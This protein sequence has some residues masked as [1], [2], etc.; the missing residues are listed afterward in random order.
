MN[1]GFNDIFRM[2]KFKKELLICFM[3]IG[4]FSMTFISQEINSTEIII[5]FGDVSEQIENRSIPRESVETNKQNLQKPIDQNFISDL[6]ANRQ[7]LLQKYLQ[8]NDV[9]NNR[10]LDGFE[11]Q[12]SEK[13]IEQVRAV[14]CLNLTSIN[15]ENDKTKLLNFSTQMGH[16][17]LSEDALY[18]SGWWFSYDLLK[19]GVECK[20]G[21]NF[22]SLIYIKSDAP[23]K[24]EMMDSFNQ[25]QLNN[26][27]LNSYGL[28]GDPDMRLAIIDRGIDVNHSAIKGKDVIWR[29]FTNKNYPNPVD[30]VGHGTEIASIAVGNH[31]NA[32]DSENRTVTSNSMYINWG[33]AGWDPAKTYLFFLGAINV[34]SNGTLVYNF[35]WS[36]PAGSTINIEKIT[37]LNENGAYTK[38][39][40]VSGPDS[41]TTLSQIINSTDLGI[42][43]FGYLFKASIGESTVHS[44]QGDIHTPL[45]VI[46]QSIQNGSDPNYKSHE[47]HGIAPNVKLAMIRVEFESDFI[48]GMTWLKNNAK[49]YNITV[50]SISLTI[51]S[52]SV[53]LLA[54]E[55]VK[56]GLVV[57]CAA[58]N[59]GIGG[60]EAGSVD[61]APGS[62]DLA[63]SVGA[64]GRNNSVSSFSA[65]GG[66]SASNK[67]IKPDI[68]AP[69]GEITARYDKNTPLIVADANA[70][71][72]F[73]ED[74]LPNASLQVVS[75]PERVINDTKFVQGTSFATPF[76][77]GVAL[78]MIEKMGG[79]KNWKYTQE[80]VLKVKNILLM[81]A[82]ETAPNCRISY[83]NS[84]SPTF[85]NGGKDKHEGAGMI[86]PLSALQLIA[87]S[88]TGDFTQN[89]TLYSPDSSVENQL[90]SYLYPGSFGLHYKLQISD[91]YEISATTNVNHSVAVYIYS[92]THTIYG[93][94][95]ILENYTLELGSGMLT[96][97]IIHLYDEQEIYIVIK[98]LNGFGI[99]NFEI[100]SIADTVKPINGEVFYPIPYT[101]LS[102]IIPLQLNSSDVHTS[103]H[104]I[105]IFAT[106][107]ND[108]FLPISPLNLSQVV[109]G[110]NNSVSWQTSTLLDGWY[111]ITIGFYDGNGNSINATAMIVAVDNTKP[112]NVIIL[113]PDEYKYIDGYIRFEYTC[114]DSFSGV[115]RVDMKYNNITQGIILANYSVNTPSNLPINDNFVSTRKVTGIFKILTT[116]AMDGDYNF[117]ITV[118]DRAGNIQ[119]SQDVKLYIQNARFGTYKRNAVYIISIFVFFGLNK[120][121][122]KIIIKVDLLKELDKIRDIPRKLSQKL[123]K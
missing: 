104:S 32:T 120:L 7:E 116:T 94:P 72:F 16:E 121:A 10:I 84:S 34:S 97:K 91:Y 36:K 18:L 82:T 107:L 86:N 71:E 44:I 33:G 60:N 61:N 70:N 64:I 78:L 102:G 41:E 6:S 65:E 19:I 17:T 69:G 89:L 118:Y 85:D 74:Q 51:P 20:S 80:E 63:I 109:L 29:D 67:V 115:S 24:Q 8:A 99:A 22:Q 88:T 112:S 122:R 105:K 14:I 39:V 87:P 79:M 38:N 28:D 40:T 54:N 68:L 9:N 106:K 100:N 35:K 83:S 11:T 45:A 52:L 92:K 46:N 23:V 110:Y 13:T 90:H 4:F 73:H 75:D 119:D 101:L 111:N 5:R 26:P 123:R 66:M 1:Y 93:E 42:Y 2:S 12:L 15:L 95:V 37:L 25:I 30:Y 96:K 27:T 108:K 98:S 53:L 81:T 21:S 114:E 103:V 55:L 49:Q 76:V 3:L 43:R 31:F 59:D 47:F 58:G 117:F 77:A 62:A 56:A 113:S 48:A 50:V 57:V